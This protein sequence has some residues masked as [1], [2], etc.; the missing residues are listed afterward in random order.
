MH[1]AHCLYYQAAG[2][3]SRHNQMLAVYQWTSVKSQCLWTQNMFH[4]N[5]SWYMFDYGNSLLR[6]YVLRC[7][8]A[9]VWLDLAT[10]TPLL[11]FGSIQQTDHEKPPNCRFVLQ[12]KCDVSR[13]VSEDNISLWNWRKP[14]D[15]KPQHNQKIRLWEL[16]AA[17]LTGELAGQQQ[18]STSIKWDESELQVWAV[19]WQQKRRSN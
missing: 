15:P 18:L 9:K 11:G 13:E 19:E 2:P 16:T 6:N 8:T 3:L 14:G 4:I 12:R 17:W 5:I 10:N 1:W 7:T